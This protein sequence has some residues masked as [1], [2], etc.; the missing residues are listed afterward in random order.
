MNEQLHW[1]ETFSGVPGWY[2]VYQA[3][4]KGN[5]ESFVPVWVE[6]AQSVPLYTAAFYGP[7]HAPELP[8]A[9]RPLEYQEKI[10]REREEAEK[11]KENEEAQEYPREEE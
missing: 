3:L 11:A 6:D 7:I 1:T 9:M 10:I 4:P 5:G 8:F 2:W